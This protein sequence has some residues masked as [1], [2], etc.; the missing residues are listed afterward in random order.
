MVTKMGKVKKAAL[1]QTV[2]DTQND[3]SKKKCMFDYTK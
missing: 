1:T 3:G 2:T